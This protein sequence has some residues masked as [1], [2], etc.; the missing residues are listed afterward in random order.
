M[1]LEQGSMYVAAYEAKFHALCRYAKM[2]VT[3][4]HKRIQ[5]FI[6]VFGYEVQVLSMHMTSVV[7]SFNEV[8]DYF[9]KVRG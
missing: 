6:T 2:C 9:N 4:E 3:M 5:L 8:I 1:V 7:R